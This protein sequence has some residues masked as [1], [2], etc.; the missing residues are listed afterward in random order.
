[1]L[2]GMQKME[3]YHLIPVLLLSICAG[4]LG[5]FCFIFV[6][7]CPQVLLLQW[8]NLPAMSWQCVELFSGVGNVSRCFREAGQSV[9]SFDTLL[10]EPMD[11]CSSAGFLL[12]AR[13]ETIDPFCSQQHPRLA[14]WLVMCAGL[15]LSF[16]LTLAHKFTAYT[17]KTDLLPGVKDLA[18]YYYV[19]RHAHLGAECPVGRRCEPGSTPL[20]WDMNLSHQPTWP[21]DGCWVQFGNC[22]HMLLF[23]RTHSIYTY[24]QK[25]IIWSFVCLLDGAWNMFHT[26]AGPPTDASRGMSLLLDHRATIRFYRHPSF[27]SKNGGIGQPNPLRVWSALIASHSNPELEKTKKTKKTC[28]QFPSP[29]IQVRILD[30]ALG[31]TFTEARSLLEHKL[32]NHPAAGHGLISQKCYIPESWDYLITSGPWWVEERTTAETHPWNH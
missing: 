26:Q 10:G 18:H 9:A 17:T 19:R 20:A 32:R 30:D 12:G 5:L 14:T 24:A 28:V 27:P 21:S 1:M 22:L 7:S 8:S 25:Y 3:S 2:F 4:C 6:W 13:F 15:F 11:M 31:I 29:G 23:L 16:W